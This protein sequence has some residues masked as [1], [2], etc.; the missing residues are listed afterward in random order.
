MGTTAGLGKRACVYRPESSLHLLEWNA[1]PPLDGE[2]GGGRLGTAVSVGKRPLAFVII[3]CLIALE[4]VFCNTCRSTFSGLSESCRTAWRRKTKANISSE[5]KRARMFHM[6]W[7]TWIC[8]LPQN[9]NPVRQRSQQYH[10]SIKVQ[11]HETTHSAETHSLLFLLE[12][13]LFWSALL[14]FAHVFHRL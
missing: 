13:P 1:C 8:Q 12:T 7:N 14:H 9:A 10:R 5:V 4:S 11:V 6:K 2:V 3:R